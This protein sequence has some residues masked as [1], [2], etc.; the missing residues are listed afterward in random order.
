MMRDFEERYEQEHNIFCPYCNHKQDTQTMYEHCT[1]WGESEDESDQN[2]YCE[3]CGKKFKVI[4]NV[5]RTYKAE[6]IE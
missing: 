6:K 1:Y 5:E 2:C 3:N 4:E